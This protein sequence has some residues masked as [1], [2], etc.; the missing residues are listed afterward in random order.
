M[1]QRRQLALLALLAV[2]RDQGMSRDKILS[3][4]WPEKDA[5]T[6]RHILNQQLYAQRQTAGEELFTGR[7][8]LRLNPAIF[9]T[10]IWDFET[11]LRAGRL[12]DAVALYKGP[13]LDGFFLREAGEFEEW[14]DAQRRRFTREYTGALEELSRIAEASGNPDGVLNWR[15]RAAEADPLDGS[16]ALA[17]ARV[18][19]HRGDRPAA[20]RELRAHEERVR[21]ALEVEAHPEVR[22][23]IADLST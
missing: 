16:A 6:A 14:V 23:L 4:L 22:R 12:E 9:Q 19:L 5:E 7:K 8:T 20:I 18:L 1:T 17:L 13:F 2:L 10:D 3:Y 15:R 21:K 11:A